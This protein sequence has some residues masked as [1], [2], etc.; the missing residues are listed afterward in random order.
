MV[1]NLKLELETRDDLVQYDLNMS[2]SHRAMPLVDSNQLSTAFKWLNQWRYLA[3][4]FFLINTIGK[5]FI[6]IINSIRE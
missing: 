4:L 5:Y 2:L 6:L 1:Y 3:I